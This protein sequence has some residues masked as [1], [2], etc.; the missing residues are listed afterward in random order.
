MTPPGRSLPES[1]PAARSFAFVAVAVLALAGCVAPSTSDPVIPSTGGADVVPDRWWEKAIPWGEGHDHGN[2]AHHANLSTPNFEVVGYDPLVTKELGTTARGMGCGGA[3]TQTEGRRLAV[4]H[5]FS[6]DVAF[7]VADVTNASAP[8]Y[9]GEFVLMNVHVWDATISADGKY[10]LLGAYPPALK[11]GWT[12]RAPTLDLDAL[13]ALEA[14]PRDWIVRP[15]FRDACTGELRQAGPEKALPLAP[16][17]ILVSLAD[18]TNPKLVDFKPQPVIG[19]HSVS[20]AL[21]DGKVWAMASVTNLVHEASYYTFF[22]VEDTAGGTL[23]PVHL[24]QVP[25]HPGPTKL[26][27]HVDVSV[28]KHPMTNKVYAY[29]A[30]WDALYV[31]SIGGVVHELVGMWADGRAGA[32]HTTLPLP[33]LRDGRHYT[34][35]GQEVGEPVELPSG[36]VYI[37]DTTDPAKPVEVGR[38]TLP[39]KPKW[40]GGLMFSPHYVE[41]VNETLFVANYHGGLWAIDITNQSD[42]RAIGIFVPDRLSP[43]PIGGKAPGPSVG[44][45]IAAPDGTL[46]V[47]DAGS[48]IYQLR[49]DATMP[50]PRAPAWP[51]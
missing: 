2:P 48:G 4:V 17:I 5:S 26:N 33:Q 7:I 31:Y 18:P 14:G 24:I 45:V 21:V 22:H 27:G 50:A 47:W 19:P 25:G 20:S 39:I 32:V 29:L 42:P 40:G 3:A 49:F 16:G 1:M 9:L 44:D 41:V 34:L 51:R 23:R 15:M 10:A 12:P 46:T 6:T 36:W 8:Q 35:V 28:A 30:N 37:L 13:A 11:P 38:W 43:K